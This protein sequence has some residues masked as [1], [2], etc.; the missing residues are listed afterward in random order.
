MDLAVIPLLLAATPLPVGSAVP[1]REPAAIRQE[2]PQGFGEQVQVEVFDPVARAAVLAQELPRRWAGTYQPF[3]AAPP[4]SVELTLSSTLALGQMVD[5][6]GE[7]T[8][9]T[10][11]I[12][13]QGNLNA[14][15][16]QLDLLLLGESSAVGLENGGEFRGLQGFSLS[17]WRAPRFTNPGGQ[18]FLTAV[19]PQAAPMPAAP[20][21]GKVIRGLW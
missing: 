9:G 2:I 12:P 5:V 13:V 8:I 20:A 4:V 14:K 15:S 18:L 7:M 11:T 17:G 19:E 21:R 3:T 16:D 10:Q 6:R 1:F